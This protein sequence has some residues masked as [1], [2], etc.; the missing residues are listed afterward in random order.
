MFDIFSVGGLFARPHK[1]FSKTRVCHFENHGNYFNNDEYQLFKMYFFTKKILFAL[2]TCF[3]DVYGFTLQYRIWN[4]L[5]CR[6]KSL[7]R[8]EAWR[9]CRAPSGLIGQSVDST[10]NNCINRQ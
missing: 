10:M 9:N 3:Y 1:L 2:F 6:I 8:R 7:G 4:R 5:L